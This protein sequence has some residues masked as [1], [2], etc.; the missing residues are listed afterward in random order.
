MDEKTFFQDL[1][2][3]VQHAKTL[4]QLKESGYYITEHPYAKRRFKVTLPNSAGWYKTNGYEDA[5]AY[6]RVIDA[7]TKE[8]P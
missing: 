3:H 6:A 8:Q 1:E 4:E 5:L 7:A 2:K